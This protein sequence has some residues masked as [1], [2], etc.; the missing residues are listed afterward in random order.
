[1]APPRKKARLHISPTAAGAIVSFL[2][3]AFV[4][5]FTYPL[6]NLHNQIQGTNY[7]ESYKETNSYLESQNLTGHIIYLPWETYLTYTWTKNASPDGRIP[8]PINRLVKPIVQTGPTEW[9]AA[10]EFQSDIEDCL[11]QNST[12]CLESLS[13]QY[14]LLD[15]CAYFPDRYSFLNQT[16][17]A[18]QDSCITI[19]RLNPKTE[20]DRTIKVPARFIVGSII[21]LLTL[22]ILIF[23]LAKKSPSH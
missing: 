2:F 19:Y 22:I 15:S 6:I 18:H 12:A 10:T 14:I 17:I 1:M 20:I 21:S 7:P 4:L 16:P 23:M 9:G 8:V 5:I 13:V 3:I 11:N